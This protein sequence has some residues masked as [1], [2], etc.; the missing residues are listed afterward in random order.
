MKMLLTSS[1]QIM[2]GYRDG[3]LEGNI[4]KAYDNLPPP[5]PHTHTFLFLQ[6]EYLNR[7][8]IELVKC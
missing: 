2:V 4:F 6:S 5:P 8:L 1:H 7:T 3:N